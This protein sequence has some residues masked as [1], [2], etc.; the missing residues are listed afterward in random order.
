MSENNLKRTPQSPKGDSLKQKSIETLLRRIFRLDSANLDFGIYRLIHLKK[1]ELYKFIRSDIIDALVLDCD[2]NFS[3]YATELPHTSAKSLQEGVIDHLISFFGRY[4]QRGDFIPHRRFGRQEKYSIPTNGEEVLLHW[5]NNQQIYVKSASNFSQ[6]R[7]HVGDMVVEFKIHPEQIAYEI[8]NKK[9]TAP[10]LFFLADIHWDSKIRNFNLIF[11][12][13]SMQKAELELIRSHTHKDRVLKSHVLSYNL[14]KVENFIADQH[15][16]HFDRL[17]GPHINVQGN[18]TKKS[19]IHWHLDRYTQSN[20]QDYFIHQN[21][22]GFLLHELEFYLKSTIPLFLL[23]EKQNSPKLSSLLS[24]SQNIV[25]RLVTQY[26]QKIIKFLSQFEDFQYKIWHK[27]KFVVDTHYCITVDYIPSELFPP[28]FS[29]KRQL[30]W[31]KDDLGFDFLKEM[32]YI[33]SPKSDLKYW[34]SQNVK[35]VQKLMEKYPGL[36]IDTQFHSKSIKQAL[37]TAI[38]GIEDKINGILIKSDNYHGLRLLQEKYQ[39]KIDLCYI[40]PPYNTGNDEFLYKDGFRHSTWLSLMDSRLGLAHSLLSRRGVLVTSLDDHEAHNYRHVV[41]QIF[42][43][44]NFLSTI[45][46]Q[47]TKSITNTAIVSQAHTYNIIY[48]KSMAYYVK[49]RSQFRLPENGEGFENPDGDIRGPWK[50]DPFQVGGWRPNQQYSITNPVTKEIYSPNPGCSWKN[51][52]KNFEKLMEDNRIVFGKTG[53]AGPQRKRFLSE[54]QQRGRV[55]STMWTDLHTTTHAT[56]D[57]KNLFG[58]S[59][60]TNP[61]PIDLI[62]RFLSLATTDNSWV[63][64]FFA[65]SGTTGHAILDLNTRE[66]SNRRFIL[67]EMGDHFETVLKPRLLKTIFSLKWKSGRPKVEQTSKQ[68]KGIPH[69]IIKYHRLEQFED[70][71]NNL[72]FVDLPEEFQENREFILTD[73]LS[74]ETKHSPTFL[75]LSLMEQPFKYRMQIEINHQRENIPI[76]LV[77]T[78]N[79]LAGISVKSYRY[80]T[81]NGNTYVWIEGNRIHNSIIASVLVIWRSTG[82]KFDPWGEQTWITNRIDLSQFDEMYINGP[83]IHAN[84]TSIDTLFKKNIMG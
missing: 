29:V 22:A 61:K 74:Y 71:L 27:P 37:L 13:K 6:Y 69:Q 72:E 26:S 66:K 45:L 10:P 56:N 52:H 77:E 17:M 35:N 63:L 78:F 46:W 68:I 24:T 79:Y 9:D 48:A 43:E 83:P 82:K 60:F 28:L 5:V 58:S 49:H 21:L 3:R 42:G 19:E 2:E 59:P 8:T 12:Y 84:F 14:H 40:D 64:D 76:D 51:D 30:E 32:S 57:L 44:S 18:P 39:D 81:N 11:K 23:E 53:E 50:A 33:E 15:S 41:D 47:S 4:Y 36:T 65:G 62:Q 20:T 55:T 1:K 73:L 25:F 54:A 31:W 7:F 16:D 80:L 38:P 70:S 34:L 75:N 67:I